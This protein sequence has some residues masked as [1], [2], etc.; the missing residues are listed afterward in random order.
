MGREEINKC[1][2]VW[3]RQPLV[4]KGYTK[5]VGLIWG[6]ASVSCAQAYKLG[7]F[8][9]HSA[10]WV[11]QWPRNSLPQ[12]IVHSAHWFWIIT[13]LEKYF[14]KFNSRAFCLF[15][16]ATTG[17]NVIFLISIFFTI[18]LIHRALR[19]NSVT[20]RMIVWKFQRDFCLLQTQL[21]FFLQWA[22][23]CWLAHIKQSLWPKVFQKLKCLQRH[24]HFLKKPEDLLLLGQ[25]RGEM[26]SMNTFW[27]F[28]VPMKEKK[29]YLP[30]ICFLI[31]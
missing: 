24:V 9:D 31:K 29:T 18:W 23:V 25:E 13:S 21:M 3:Q 2:N 16:S 26:I 8:G 14:G 15:V 30:L 1:S 10:H 22:V 12:K 11:R 6:T 7:N 27:R 19:S 17:L 20:T 4:N 28:A 5:Q